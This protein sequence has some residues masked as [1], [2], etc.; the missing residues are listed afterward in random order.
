[1]DENIKQEINLPD[2]IPIFPLDGVVMFPN[3]Y[4]PLNIFEPRYLKM[5]DKAISSKSRLVGMIQP[6]NLNETDNNNTLYKVGCAGKI[7]KFEET[8]DKRYLITLEGKSRF[9]LI[10]ENINDKNFR[11]ASICWKNFS[12]D[13]DK[14][15]KLTDFSTLK[16]IL[17]K[18]FKSQNIRA[19]MD[20]IDS[21][22]D[23]NFVDQITMI[24][25]LANNEKQLLLETKSFTKRKELLQAILDTHVSEANFKD[26]SKH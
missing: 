24:C 1:M 21:F 6:K 20:E 7:V 13:L 11:E 18:Y 9:D 3:T 8:V 19:N 26:I 23:H 22:N 4:L 5:I 2:I 12:E 17:K 10:S 25:P 15:V 14:N 16:I